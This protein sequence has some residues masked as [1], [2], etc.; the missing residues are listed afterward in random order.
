MRRQEEAAR[1]VRKSR[2]GRDDTQTE[3]RHDYKHTQTLHNYSS[4]CMSAAE[5]T[6]Q[7]GLAI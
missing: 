1:V 4:H 5:E 2:G 3:D 6:L 7:C